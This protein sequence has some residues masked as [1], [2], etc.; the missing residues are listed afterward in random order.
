MHC[1]EAF[2]ARAHCRI[3]IDIKPGTVGEPK[4]VA[5]V[6]II[7]DASEQLHPLIFRSGNRIAF[8]A[9][10]EAGALTSTLTYLE[11]RFGAFSE[12][13]HG[14]LISARMATIGEPVVVEEM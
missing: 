10:S 8:P 14:C 3:D 4:Y 2:F 13:M 6:S 9:S 5:T 11:K 7:D 1:Q 12:I